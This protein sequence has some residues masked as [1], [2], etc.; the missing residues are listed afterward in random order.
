MFHFQKPRND[1][2]EQN[3]Q[4]L[5]DLFNE[6]RQLGEDANEA[7]KKINAA[8]TGIEKLRTARAMSTADEDAPLANPDDPEEKALYLFS[9]VILHSKNTSSLI[10]FSFFDS[11][12]T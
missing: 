11:D 9:A 7:R 6:A 2:F 10:P 4:L 8:K 12:T 1:S 5:A 3:K